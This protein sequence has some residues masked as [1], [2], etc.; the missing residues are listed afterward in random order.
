MRPMY[1]LEKAKT[2]VN[3]RFPSGPVTIS[4]KMAAPGTE[5]SVSVPPGVMRPILPLVNSVNQRFPSGPLVTSPVWVQ[6]SGG[7]LKFELARSCGVEG[8][9]ANPMRTENE[10]KRDGRIR[11]HQSWV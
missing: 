3:Q 5:N 9:R 10:H 6:D 4:R 8:S 1:G 2:S 7:I 11:S